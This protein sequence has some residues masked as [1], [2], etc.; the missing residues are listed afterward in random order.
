MIRIAIF[1]AFLALVSYWVHR[2]LVRA[3]GLT[4]RPARAVDVTLIVL[5]MLALVGVGSGE[6]FDPAWARIPASSAGYGLQL[7]STSCSG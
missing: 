5:W 6:V 2:R 3:T 7:C 4:G 1:G